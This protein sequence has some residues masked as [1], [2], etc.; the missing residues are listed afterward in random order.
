MTQISVTPELLV[1]TIVENGV[2]HVPYLP[3]IEHD[4]TYQL[5]SKAPSLTMVP[6]S[7]E[8]ETMAIA[9][10]LIVGGKKPLIVIQNTGMFESGDSI[11]GFG[12]YARIP[13]VMMVGYRGWDPAGHPKDSAAVYT[14]PVLEA[15]GIRS[16]PIL[17]D[18]DLSRIAA[19]YSTATETGKPTAILLPE[20]TK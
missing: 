12:H 8:G 3:D 1:R 2:T 6:V 11:R 17:E 10:G 19:A 14:E 7:R 4:S 16:F 13:F 5:M 18:A 9:A 15:W 20:E